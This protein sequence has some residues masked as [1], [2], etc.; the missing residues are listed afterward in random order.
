ML[1]CSQKVLLASLD[2]SEDRG[3]F[4][5][6]E[7]VVRAWRMF[8]KDFGLRLFNDCHPDSNRVLARVMGARGLCSRGL[9]ERVAERQY[10]ITD[11]GKRAAEGTKP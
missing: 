9:L 4:C 6:E 8:P 10:R 7:L 3:V 5:A 11:K 1:S 2:L